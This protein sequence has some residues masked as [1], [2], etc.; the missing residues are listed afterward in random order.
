MNNIVN[1]V[2]INEKVYTLQHPG[3]REWLKLQSQMLDI[4]TKTLDMEKLI[5][6][7]FENVVIPLVGNKLDLDTLPVQDLGVWQVLLP[8]F[9]RGEL[10]AGYVYPDDKK[11]KREG[12]RIL[13]EASAK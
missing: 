11:S 2:V 1:R 3:N 9:L 13:E 6:Y 8:Q 7:C 4:N 5:D 10:D 12:K